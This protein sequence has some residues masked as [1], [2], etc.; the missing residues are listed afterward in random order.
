M[1]YEVVSDLRHLRSMSATDTLFL[2]EVKV[3]SKFIT[4]NAA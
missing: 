3:G 4:D 1:T 2:L